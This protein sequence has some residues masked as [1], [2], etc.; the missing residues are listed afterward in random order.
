MIF[1][2]LAFSTAWVRLLTSSFAKRFWLWV[3]TV[4]NETKIFEAI[5][6]RNGQMACQDLVAM[7]GVTPATVSHHMRILAGTGLVTGQRRGQWMWYCRDEAAVKE[8]TK[9]FREEI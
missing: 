7:R 2:L 4:L 6:S 1:N 8:M 3:F 5:S 9:K